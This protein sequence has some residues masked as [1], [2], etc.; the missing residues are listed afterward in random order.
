M[1][2]FSSDINDYV[3]RVVQKLIDPSKVKD[4][5]RFAYN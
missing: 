1:F 2:D 3:D 5:M 4:K